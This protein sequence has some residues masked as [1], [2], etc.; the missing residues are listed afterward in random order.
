[1]MSLRYMVLKIEN[2]EQRFC[3]CSVFRKSTKMVLIANEEYTDELRTYCI[4]L[5]VHFSEEFSTFDQGFYRHKLN[6]IKL[7]SQFEV[8]V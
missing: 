2:K 7:F 5:I 6:Q 8:K 3:G 4:K 1:M